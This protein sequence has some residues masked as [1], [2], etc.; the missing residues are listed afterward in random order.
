MEQRLGHP[1]VSLALVSVPT[2]AG[3]PQALHPPGLRR[4]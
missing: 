4:S 2:H 1:A 3:E